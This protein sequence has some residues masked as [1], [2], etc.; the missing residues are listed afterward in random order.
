MAGFLAATSA[1]AE[2]VVNSKHNLSVSGPGTVRAAKEAQVCIFCHTPHNAT[3]DA[4]LWNRYASGANYQPYSSTTTKAIIGQPT[5]SSKL[6]LSCHDGTIALGKVR[7]RADDIPFTRG[8][9]RM[10]PGRSNIGTDL[11]DDHPISFRY[12]TQLTKQDIQLYDPIKFKHDPVHLDAQGQMQCTS[13]HDA[14]DN[15]F[16]MF[17]VKDNTASALCLTCHDIQNWNT[18]DHAHSSAAWNKHGNNPWPHTKYLTV[19]ENACENCHA[20]HAAQTKQR[21]LNYVKEEDNCFTCH[22]GN[23]AAKNIEAEFLKMSVHPVSSTI[24]VH[25]PLED[26][27]NSQRHVE[28]ADCHN[29]HATR[30]SEISGATLSGAL[31]GVAGVNVSGAV[32]K[33]AQHEYELCFRCHADS[34]DRGKALIN[35]QYAESNTRMQFA[36]GNASF[37]PVETMGKNPNV[38]SLLEPYRPSSTIACT[39]CH[40]NDSGPGAGGNGPKGPHG[41][42]Y[43]PLLERSLALTDGF[44]SNPNDAALCFK[45]HN[46]ES[47]MADESFPSHSLHINAGESCVTCHDPHG[48]ARNTNLINF[49]TD[50]ALPLRGIVQFTDTGLFSGTCTM[51]C[52]NH[53]HDQL[54]YTAGQMNTSVISSTNT[55]NAIPTAPSPAKSLSIPSPFRTPARRPAR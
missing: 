5:G 42:I 34:V 41:S 53:D 14:H 3:S 15:R 8:V 35:R 6:C 1:L 2:S 11:S 16:G 36:Q 26:I 30:S 17:L 20:P 32:I 55:V 40:N 19:A 23:V 37:H 54:S 33:P 22:N 28:C 50:Y 47:I 48:V 38:P 9:T 7:S 4:P 52:H 51:T 12:D 39:D 49:N 21:L 45:C 43:R 27:I 25:D 44:G 46:R 29:P 24:G 31:L 13:C 10:P 18:S